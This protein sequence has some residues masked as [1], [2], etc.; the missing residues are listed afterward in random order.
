MVKNLLANAWDRSLIP[1][2]EDILEKET[3]TPSSILAW[4]ILLTERGACRA[5][6]HRTTRVWHD[7]E[8]NNKSLPLVFLKYF[9]LLLPLVSVH[10]QL[11]VTLTK[12]PCFV[13]G[14]PYTSKQSD[15]T[16]NKRTSSIIWKRNYH[17]NNL[18]VCLCFFI[19]WHLYHP[20][21]FTL[22]FKIQWNKKMPLHFHDFIYNLTRR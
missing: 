20:I 22:I 15:Y 14:E 1:G 16:Y 7:L 9:N 3:A 21:Y 18:C 5:T 11:Y 6:V 13:W 2:Q 19:T 17:L 8:T 4:E 10:M 12:W